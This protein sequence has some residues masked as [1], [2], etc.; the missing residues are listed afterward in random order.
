MTDAPPPGW[1]GPPPPPQMPP[2]GGPYPASYGQ[3][4]PPP[5]YAQYSPYGGGGSREHPQGT[6][7]LLLGILRLVIC[8]LLG[9]VA[10]IMGQKAIREM[11]SDPSTSYM[12]RGK[13]NA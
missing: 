9:P 12:N 11:D 4:P 13:V 6:T 1:D 10:W 2:G 8:G 5:G 3:P 7:I